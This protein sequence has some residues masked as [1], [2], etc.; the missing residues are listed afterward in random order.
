MYVNVLLA[1]A[2]PLQRKLHVP[3]YNVLD[4]IFNCLK[5]TFF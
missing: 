1:L 3:V 5:N 2:Y 4:H